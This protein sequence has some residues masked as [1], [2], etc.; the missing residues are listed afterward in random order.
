MVGG[1]KA[2]VIQ[3]KWRAWFDKV[4]AGWPVLQIKWKSTGE[5][6]VAHAG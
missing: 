5:M 4:T 6:A 2:M 1:Q 3:N